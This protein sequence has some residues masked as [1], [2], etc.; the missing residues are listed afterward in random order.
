MNL[1]YSFISIS[2]ANKK[3]STYSR[4][5][6]RR[7]PYVYWFWIF[8][9]PYVIA[10]RLFKPLCLFLF[11]IG[12]RLWGDLGELWG[13]SKVISNSI[14]EE[15]IVFIFGICLAD[16][17]SFRES[18]GTILYQLRNCQSLNWTQKLKKFE[19]LGKIM[20]FLKSLHGCTQP[21][22]TGW[23]VQPAQIILASI[24]SPAQ[25][26]QHNQHPSSL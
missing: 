15:T 1:C 2:T 5:Q 7:K 8:S 10:L 16:P 22:W 21:V 4:L 24:A 13:Q 25:P 12:G 14:S 11:V 20:E 17:G 26:A 9:S 19:S 6:N 18:S 23:P 3:V